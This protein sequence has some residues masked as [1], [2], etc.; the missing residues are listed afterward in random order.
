MW[1]DEFVLLVAHRVS[2]LWRLAIVQGTINARRKGW[3]TINN[4]RDADDTTP[5]TGHA[6]EMAAEVDR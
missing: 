2:V 3:R 4:L 6:M 5:G 1:I